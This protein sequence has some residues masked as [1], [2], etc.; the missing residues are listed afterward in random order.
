MLSSIQSRTISIGYCLVRMA[1]PWA[2][3]LVASW[4]RKCPM[5][6]LRLSHPDKNWL[7]QLQSILWHMR[8]Y[9]NCMVRG[10]AYRL[11]LS[12]RIFATETDHHRSSSHDQWANN[13]HHR[14]E[15]APRKVP[16]SHKRSRSSIHNHN[17]W[18]W[19]HYESYADNLGEAT[20]LQQTC[21]ADRILRHNHE[22][23]QDDRS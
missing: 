22:C 1:A 17:S 2:T 12:H 23:T 15:G 11:C 21:S 8:H 10:R 20:H 16:E 7:I 19:C 14:C 18:P 5:L 13:R 4:C 9:Q 6:Q 3:Q